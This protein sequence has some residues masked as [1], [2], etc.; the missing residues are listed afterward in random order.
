MA[1]KQK[2]QNWIAVR[3]YEVI[4]IFKDRKDAVKYFKEMLKQ[5]LKDF[6]KQDVSDE[7]DYQ[8]TIPQIEFYPIKEREAYLGLL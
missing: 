6:D 1:R 8:I 7:Y 5:T 3:N 2:K 4:K